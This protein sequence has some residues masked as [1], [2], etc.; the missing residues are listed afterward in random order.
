MAADT[1]P[2]KRYI[3]LDVDPKMLE[4]H[5]VDY[6]RNSMEYVQQDFGVPF[7]KLDSSLQKL[8][9]QIDFLFSNMTLHWIPP[10]SR[11][12]AAN[13]IAKLL[14]PGC[15][16]YLN[17]IHLSE[18]VL[19][20]S[21]DDAEI[22]KYF[23]VHSRDEQMFGWKEELC[24][25]GLTLLE[26]ICEKKKYAYKTEQEFRMTSKLSRTWEVYCS[27]Q[28]V[29]SDRVRVMASLEEPFLRYYRLPHDQK[30]NKQLS[31]GTTIYYELM[32]FVV[33]R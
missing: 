12:N 9:G 10:A 6:H 20:Y 16:A 8:E 30:G 1:I 21:D 26:A 32:T 28:V 23:R 25:Q 19:D 24:R 5:A 33:R 15:V 22:K 31:E 14:R 18:Q 2:H 17:I 27:D 11:G 7:E 4:F 13:N 3:A 29:G